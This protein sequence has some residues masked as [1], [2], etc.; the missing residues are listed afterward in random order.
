MFL[1]RYIMMKPLCMYNDK[2]KYFF[3][4]FNSWLY[5]SIYWSFSF[6]FSW[7]FF[8]FIQRWQNLFFVVLLKANLHPQLVWHTI[9]GIEMVVTKFIYLFIYLF[10]ANIFMWMEYCVGII[11][12]RLLYLCLC[13]MHSCNAYFVLTIYGMCVIMMLFWMVMFMWKKHYDA[14]IY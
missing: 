4:L 8:V 11:F 10:C 12:L 5:D 6:F 14:Y 2:Y 7:S 13:E 1:L 3:F 9:V